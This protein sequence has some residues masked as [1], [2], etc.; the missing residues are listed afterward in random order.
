VV[1]LLLTPLPLRGLSLP[2]RIAL[3]PM[4]QY[5]VDL[6]D[7][8]PTDWH[9]VH[10]GARAAGG[11]GL[12]LTEATAVSPEGR[13]SPQDTGLWN[14][15]QQQAWLRITD[16]LHAR[17][18]VTG[19]QLAHAGR[20]ASTF[21]PF[22]DTSGSV[23]LS[24]GG[25]P[26]VGPSAEPFPGLAT[27]SALDPD[28]LAT[29]VADFAAAA[30][31][32]VRAG[33]DVIEIHAAHGYLLHEFLSPL[34]NHRTDGYG[35]S[36]E[37]RARLLTEVV[38]AVRSVLPPAAPLMV[39]VSATDWVSGGLTADETVRVGGWLRELGVD[40]ID[41]STGGNALAEIPLGPGYQVPFAARVRAEAGVPTGAVG[42]ISDPLHAEQIL[43]EGAA[44]IVL[45]A[46]AALREPGWPWR[47]AF[48]LGADV[49]AA[50][51]PQQ[52]LRGAWR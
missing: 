19:V 26:T 41:V 27:P 12:V 6:R 34:S 32:A 1:S 30:E 24:D 7:G 25:W 13:I 31:R 33:F 17:G 14:D 35:G 40:L 3:A 4:C 9:L 28:G 38:A 18:A 2:N 37:N 22:A 43:A 5:S 16:F 50:R 44:D 45:L 52:Y 51:Y 39:R 15:A 21:A 11:F 29:V 49:Q 48:E 42:L 47:A 46:R 20:K 23:P 10:L 8:V 36:L